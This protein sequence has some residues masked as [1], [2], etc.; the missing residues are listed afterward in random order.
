MHSLG[1]EVANVSSRDLALGPVAVHDLAESLGVQLVSANVQVR[2]RPWL[3]PYVVLRRHVDGRDL[4]V[5]ITGVTMRGHTDW[6][7]SLGL[8]ITDPRAAARDILPVLEAQSDLVVLLAYMPAADVDT[9]AVALRGFDVFVSG[10]GD[11][12]DLPR[13]GG[14]TP[15]VLAPG[16]KAKQLAWVALRAE[17]DGFLVAAGG[18]QGLDA[19]VGDDPEIA[20][21]VAG[22]KSRLAKPPATPPEPT[23]APTDSDGIREAAPALHG[24]AQASPGVLRVP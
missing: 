19:K 5:G 7:D 24:A 2:G 14:R 16:T 1:L 22:Y 15:A 12:R 11:A 17:G 21:R 4:R 20:K 10:S 3:Q 18:M 8:Q 6:P 13:P 9:L 23:I